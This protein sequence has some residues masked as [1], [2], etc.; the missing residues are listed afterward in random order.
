MTTNEER[1][2]DIAKEVILLNEHLGAMLTGSLML[3][4]RGINKRREATD[5]DIICSY[6][7]E[8]KDGYPLVPTGFRENKMSGA[9]SQVDAIK[10]QNGEGVSIDFMVSEECGVEIDGIMCGSV[11]FLISAKKKYIE[12]DKN[13]ES[14]KKHELDLTFLYENNTINL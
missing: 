12:N 11:E 2:L 1:L 3:S 10:F 9:K 7:C 13:E 5:I 14:R 8:G 4:V 6:L